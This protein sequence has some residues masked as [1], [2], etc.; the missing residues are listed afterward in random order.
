MRS[1]FIRH[2]FDN[3]SN[4]TLGYLINSLGFILVKTLLLLFSFSIY[5]LMGCL[6]VRKRWLLKSWF[7]INQKLLD[8]VLLSLL[9]ILLSSKIFLVILLPLFFFKPDHI[10]T[11]FFHLLFEYYLSHQFFFVNSFLHL[12]LTLILANGF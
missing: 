7:I 11:F 4:L 12:K 9:L 8:L 2:S 6:F 5:E 10:L 3:L 1:H